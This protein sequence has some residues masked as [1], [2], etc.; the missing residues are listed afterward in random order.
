MGPA[1]RLLP[2]LALIA[3][4]ALLAGCGAGRKDDD[5][6]VL[7]V[8]QRNEPATLDPHLA[9]LPDELFVLRALLEGLTVPDPDGGPA[10]PGAA[11]SWTSS[12]D[13]RRFTFRLRADG[14]WSDG[15][16]VTAADFLYSFRRA[17]TPALASPRAD[18]FQVVRN[19]AAYRRGELT[20]FAQVGVSAPDDRTLVVET[21]EPT[22]HLPAIAASGAWLPVHRASVEAAGGP[23]ARD[24]GWTRPGAHVGNGPFLLAEWRPNRHLLLRPNPRHRDAA[25]V[26]V[27]A[28]RLQVYDSGD[29]E[30]RAFRAGQ[31]EVTMSVPAAKLP[32]YAPPV[33]RR[34][35]L[36]ETRHLVLNLAR[37]PLGD[38]RV[39]QALS[40]AL[41]RDALV[42]SV[43]R[44]GQQ[45]AHDFI[46]PGLGGYA[47]GPRLRRDPEEARRLLAAA[48]YPGGRGFP[49]LELSAWGVSAAILEAMQQMWLRELGI[50]TAI[51]QRE[52]K[53]HLA[54]VAAGD[55]DLAF[56]PAIPDFDD[57]A[58]LLEDWKSGAPGNYA[59]WSSARYDGLLA[60]AA[61]AADPAERRRL[62]VEAEET[63]LADLP[64][65]PVYFNAQNYLVSPRVRGWRQ[66][67]LW[68]RYY[69][70]VSL[71]TVR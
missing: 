21:T 31:L 44:G 36:H 24:G 49:P 37:P 1:P 12:D 53:V 55:F 50:E 19:A 51:V 3:A 71:E 63:L 65:I 18:L 69:L 22:P 67:A 64:L 29:T 39:R 57:P 56:L 40:L 62:H 43:L 34:Q 58:A 17:L 42:T 11:E 66:D 10:R 23:A 15:T 68:N 9:T 45:V 27:G 54:A 28:V 7:R 61:R 6:S 38:P 5:A 35:P 32:A 47:G 52:G 33:L 70:D 4:C 60:A 48:G 41:D 30:E 20:D 13:F 16:P 26:Q 46:P 2:A 14:R 8:S 25:R 59:R